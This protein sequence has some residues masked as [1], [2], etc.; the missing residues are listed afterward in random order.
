MD[1]EAAPNLS[2]FS[3]A[4]I[5]IIM[6]IECSLVLNKR[7]SVVAAAG[8]SGC[9]LLPGR[10]GSNEVM[11]PC[12]CFGRQLIVLVTS[13]WKTEHSITLNANV[14]QFVSHFSWFYSNSARIWCLPCKLRSTK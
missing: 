11:V 6:S 1:E 14:L 12:D 9:S 4:Q 7:V 13:E 2:T 8:D 10:I 5:I 3:D